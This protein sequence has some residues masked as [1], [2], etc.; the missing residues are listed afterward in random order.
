MMCCCRFAPA[1]LLPLVLFHHVE[2]VR[3]NLRQ[4]SYLEARDE[5]HQHIGGQCK[6][7][8]LLLD[9]ACP[10]LVPF[11]RPEEIKVSVG[12]KEAIRRAQP[13]EFHV[14]LRP[15]LYVVDFD[16]LRVFRA[17]HVVLQH[18]PEQVDGQGGVHGALV[19]K[20][21]G[22]SLVDGVLR[23]EGHG[24]DEGRENVPLVPSIRP[25]QE[26]AEVVLTFRAHVNPKVDFLEEGGLG[27]VHG[28]VSAEVFVEHEVASHK[29]EL[30]YRLHSSRALL[31]SF[32]HKGF[33]LLALGLVEEVP[34]L[35]NLG[36]R[37]L[38]DRCRLALPE[39]ELDGRH[40]GGESVVE[41]RDLLDVKV[42]GRCA[43][44]SGRN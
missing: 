10:L 23:R 39:L 19:Q 8:H 32:F 17:A 5:R 14:L 9:A 27:L 24:T 35:R 16:V 4:D 34:I 25:R 44:G 20:G 12:V 2:L 37:R 22:K 33:Q 41:A 43:G 18:L 28:G 30:E 31:D 11:L 42:W 29:D 15:A 38:I 7:W 6:D 21:R 13:P 36:G 40:Q 3:L 26:A 1:F